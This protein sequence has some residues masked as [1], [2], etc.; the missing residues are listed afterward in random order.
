MH[1]IIENVWIAIFTGLVLVG[2]LLFILSK[3][4]KNRQKDYPR[5]KRHIIKSTR[6]KNTREPLLIRLPKLG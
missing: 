4:S 2:G 5:P 3:T 1:L 6:N